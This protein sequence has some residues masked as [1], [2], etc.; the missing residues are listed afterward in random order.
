MIFRRKKD[1][2]VIGDAAVVPSEEEVL[3][4]EETSDAEAAEIEADVAT[5]V[6]AND[7]GQDG[8]EVEMIVVDRADGP[9]DVTEV[10]PIDAES[11]EPRIDLGAVQ[12]PLV[13]E[14]E[15]R[16]EVDE[17]SGQPVAVTLIRG[18][19]A[20]QVRA[21]SAPRTPGMWDKAREEI[22]GEITSDGGLVDVLAGKFGNEIWASVPAKDDQGNQGMQPIRVV[23]VEGPRWMLQGVFLGAGANADTSQDL[24]SVFRSIVVVR[25]DGPMAPQTALQIV[26]PD[27]VPAEV[28]ELDPA[29][30][31][32]QV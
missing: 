8:A 5:A 28:E 3:A 21:Y 30:D 4:Q 26:I 1:S 24:E 6:A 14:L 9:F 23:G 18:E 13:D 11:P 19:G 32:P 2:E 17:S 22:S 27:R 25:G 29:D 15:I 10:E 20:V 16:I 7:N 31:E 12:V